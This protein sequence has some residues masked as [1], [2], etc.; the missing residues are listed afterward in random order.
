M[1]LSFLRPRQA[2]RSLGRSRGFTSAAV[3][4]LGLGI[5]MS[6][7]MFTVYRAVL[8]QRLPIADQSRVVIMHPLDR[9]GAHLDVPVPYLDELR[10]DGKT[11]AGIAGVYHQGAMA[12]P[13]LRDGKALDL[14]SGYVTANLFDVLGVRPLLGRML[15][16]D[17]GEQGTPA[18]IVISYATWRR[19][20][21]ED[22]LVIGRALIAP[23]DGSRITIVG[24]A[25]PGFEYPVGADAWQPVRR[26]MGE[27][28][29][30]DI[31]ARL[32]PGASVDAAR[33]E[34]L[35]ITQRVNPFV[36]F[37]GKTFPPSITDADAHAFVQEVLGT[38]R[39]ALIVLS[40]AVALLLVIACV[41]V[42][43]LLIVRGAG[44][45]REFAVR[46][47]IGASAFDLAAQLLLEN[48]FLGAAGGVLGL[49]LAQVLLRVLLYLAP[50]QLPRT[51]VIRVGGTSLGIA[52][53]TSILAVLVFGLVPALGAARTD[54]NN[55]LRSDSR[56]GAGVAQRRARQWLVS[57]QVALALV[58]LAGA[59]LLG[60]SLAQLQSLDLGYVPD[61]VTFLRLTGP[62][63]D[64]DTP[65]KSVHFVDDLLARIHAVP[66]VI[67]ATSVESPPFKGQSL[68]LTKMSRAELSDVE[69]EA[70]PY[71]P[72][73]TADVDYF[74]T[75]QIP[76]VRGRG[77]QPADAKGAARV[78]VVSEGLA[79]RLWPGEDPVG[80]RMRSAYDSLHTNFTVV[81]VAH[82]TH[83]RELRQSA[84]AIYWPRA[85][86]EYSAWWGYIAVR[87][88]GAIASV[89][90]S[91]Q[92][93][94]SDGHP[95]VTV[96]RTETMDH[97]LDAPLAQP[98]MSTFLLSAFGIVALMLAAIGLYGVMSS[99]VRQQTREIGIRVAL[100]A[101]AGRVR[102]AVISE[103]MVVVGAGSLVGLVAAIAST[104]LLRT[105]LF[106]VSPIDPLSLAT[107]CALLIAVGLAAAYFPARYATRI[108]PARAL[109]AD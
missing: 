63:G 61:Q 32:A 67:A 4:L 59:L 100:G 60:R 41:N 81:G 73:E 8:V 25:P 1:S 7:A 27:Q 103:A 45:A 104:R 74:R 47:A 56:V 22:S 42:G 11:I 35:S 31:V 13:L 108:D 30:V 69:L 92:R 84:P 33:A 48:G 93:A 99:A 18:V 66:G 91:I 95:G 79:R 57:S 15:R 28:L 36:E 62:E 54:P 46:R 71:I 50:A 43:S 85:Q 65:E 3:I 12:S 14:S 34:L 6:T 82:D 98:R 70:A 20:F 23:Y 89:L 52:I 2:L 87:S 64:F 88:G 86:Q 77:F 106:G 83:F 29:Q 78:V 26:N 17:D 51:D 9:G 107:A 68:F 5:G 10:R 96:V 101:T 21:G 53:G 38:V 94:V 55:A 44:R 80:K 75:F 76:I 58:M 40:A 49:L 97:L 19:V 72:F 102:G 105:Q 37:R 90:P 39:P 16:P 24:V 109:R